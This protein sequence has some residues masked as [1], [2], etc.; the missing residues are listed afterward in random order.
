MLRTGNGGHPL[1]LAP[2]PSARS[3]WG[4][5]A[6][7][8]LALLAALLFQTWA[9]TRPVAVRHALEP[10]EKLR[11]VSY[12]PFHRRGQT[13]FDEKL[14]ISR[15]QIEEDLEALSA[16]TDC[17]R[18]YATDAGLDQVP[19]VAR[20][21]G[22]KVLLGVWISFDQERNAAALEHAIALANEYRDVVRALI[23]GNE[24]LL[25]HERTVD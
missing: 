7:V 18:I 12:G 1:N 4:A 9:Q 10:G 14:T 17:V 20:E 13:P 6:L 5:L 21:R 15:A 16:L 8:H 2:M 3:A 23:V 22:M 11:C 19:A 24:V 25:R